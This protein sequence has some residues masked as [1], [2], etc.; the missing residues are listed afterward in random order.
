[1]NEAAVNTTNTRQD[2]NLAQHNRPYMNR[3]DASL[4]SKPGSNGNDLFKVP[5]NVN[6]EDVRIIYVKPAESETF[7]TN[8]P[9]NR[10]TSFQGNGYYNKPIGQQAFLSESYQHNSN[11]TNDLEHADS[12]LQQQQ[13]HLE[14]AV[15]A[16]PNQK[17]G[18]SAN[19]KVE[20]D[21]QEPAHGQ[22]EVVAIQDN[23]QATL[24]THH[25]SEGVQTGSDASHRQNE[26]PSRMVHTG[27]SS[28]ESWSREYLT[29]VQ[30]LRELYQQTREN[31]LP[32]WH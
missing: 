16:S 5:I 2:G 19:I 10:T 3:N 32:C 18:P 6:P 26:M 9:A 17:Y 24:N 21:N 7:S 27:S 12:R 1:M 29:L 4:T 23:G 28:L 30:K 14:S 11:N 25:E 22:G 15:D 13:G 31:T 20:I 8:W